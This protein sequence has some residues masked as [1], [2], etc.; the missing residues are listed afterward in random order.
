MN[1]FAKWK[2]VIYLASIIGV[3]GLLINGIYQTVNAYNDSSQLQS[4][5]YA[6]IAGSSP[7]K[8]ALVPGSVC[9]PYG[10]AGCSGCVK[11]QY[12]Q[13]IKVLPGFSTGIEQMY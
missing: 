9:N 2:K 12:Q 1:R 10:C 8:S 5:D 6:L 3:T 11:L 13:S 7:D 4:A